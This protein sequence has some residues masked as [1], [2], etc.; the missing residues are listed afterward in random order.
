LR[1]YF[2]EG[3]HI[4]HTSF[5]LPTGLFRFPPKSSRR[6]KSAPLRLIMV[7]FIDRDFSV[8]SFACRA[9]FRFNLLCV[10]SNT[11]ALLWQADVWAAGRTTLGGA[12][13]HRISSIRKDDL[14]ANFGAES[15]G[16]YVETF[17]LR[18]VR[19][20]FRFCTCYWFNFSEQ[21]NLR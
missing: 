8:V 17:D 18:T 4:G 6:P 20:R 21:W 15:H 9:G 13:V 2:F 19:N 3:Q 1:S 12:E 11:G 5:Q 7:A 10:D 16:A 14:I